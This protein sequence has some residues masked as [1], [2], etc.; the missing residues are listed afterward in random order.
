MS[1]LKNTL[2]K[3]HILALCAVLLAP[4]IAFA[5]TAEE[6]DS[7]FKIDYSANDINYYDPRGNNVCGQTTPTG[8]AVNPSQH[9]AANVKVILG[10]V[11]SL[12][13]DQKAAL[14][15]LM[16][17]LQESN[18]TNLASK[19]IPISLE[20]PDKQGE[21]KGDHDSVGVFQQRVGSG[22]STFGSGETKEIVWQLM[23]VAYSAQA[24]LGVP[25]DAKLPS[26]LKN[27][28]ALK[29]GLQSIDNWQS[30]EPGVAAQKVQISAYPDA[31]AKHQDKAQKLINQYW[32]QSPPVPLPIPITGGTASTNPN[33]QCATSN[34]LSSIILRYAWP[35]YHP[36]PYLV[37]KGDYKAAVE[38]AQDN[39]VYVGGAEHPGIDCG[40]FVTLV[41]RNSGIDPTYN[42][43]KSNVVGQKDYL[44]SH[45]EKFKLLTNVGS[46]ADLQ[47]G[48]IYIQRNL[49]HTY[50]YVGKIPGFN[51]NA[52]SASIGSTWRTPMASNVQPS[53]LSA[54]W[55][56]PLN[57]SSNPLTQ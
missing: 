57:V 44:D 53:E 1:N 24:F 27:P 16:T 35:D 13:L 45:P 20:N 50:L 33:T 29:K 25:K 51:G 56:R 18:I 38:T 49:Q 11:K 7:Q 40:G 28:G 55:Y 48:D 19:K 41:M 46:T 17:A 32:D 37:M 39:G 54:Y 52:A 8:Q 34:S 12:N 15:A 31:Y 30:L 23:T 36:A 2:L 43:K 5:Q 22:W 47:P 26:N 3:I 4:N 10:I 14:V 42:D 6:K 21:A 9:Q